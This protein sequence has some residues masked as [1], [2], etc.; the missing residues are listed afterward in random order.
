MQQQFRVAATPGA[1]HI[2]KEFGYHSGALT[3]E[4]VHD[5]ARTAKILELQKKLR[6]AYNRHYDKIR[7]N[8]VEIERLTLEAIES[9]LKDKAEIDKYVSKAIIAAAKHDQHI[10]N[11]SRNYS[12]N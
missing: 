11:L 5:A 1:A 10:V 3:A 9:G 7:T 12:T 4:M 2:Q 8:K 6:T